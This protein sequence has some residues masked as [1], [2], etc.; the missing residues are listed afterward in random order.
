MSNKIKKIESTGSKYPAQRFSGSYEY[1]N[2]FPADKKLT[3][4]VKVIYFPYPFINIYVPVKGC[5]TWG[6]LFKRIYTHFRK[7]YW[8]ESRKNE[9]RMWHYLEDYVVEMV[10]IY[11]DGLAEVY[12]GS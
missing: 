11:D 9:E 3:V 12:I 1:C 4:P 6:G 8:Q 7:L 2:V 10:N 5:T